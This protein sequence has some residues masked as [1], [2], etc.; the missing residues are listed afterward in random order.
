VDLEL[1]LELT[2]ALLRRDELGALPRSETWLETPVYAVLPAPGVDRL[3]A[4]AKIARDICHLAT[5]LDE[6][7]HAT[8]KL[9][10]VTLSSHCCLLSG[11]RSGIQ[12]FDSTRPGADQ[13]DRRVDQVVLCR[14][15]ADAE[16]DHG[17]RERARRGHDPGTGLYAAGLNRGG[18][19]R[20]LSA[21]CGLRWRS[22]E[23]RI[24]V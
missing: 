12:Y 17:V 23:E 2:D 9:R 15:P 5:G 20:H 11:Q 6:V 14:R 7:E 16:G 18:T 13:P 21:S 8:A 22:T 1:G 24:V 4:D 3:T 10:W 19:R